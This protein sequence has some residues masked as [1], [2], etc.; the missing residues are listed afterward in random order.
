MTGTLIIDHTTDPLLKLDKGATNDNANLWWTFYF[1]CIGTLRD[2]QRKIQEHNQM[3][4]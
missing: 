4:N 1:C 3:D 2:W